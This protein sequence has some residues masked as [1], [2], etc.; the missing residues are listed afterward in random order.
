MASTCP[1]IDVAKCYTNLMLCV[2]YG[3]HFGIS[4]TLLHNISSDGSSV[5]V[6]DWILFAFLILPFIVSY[7]IS[8]IIII[9]DLYD[10]YN[11]DIGEMNPM[12]PF[13]LIYLIIIKQ[14][15][16]IQHLGNNNN[17]SNNNNNDNS[18]AFTSSNILLINYIFTMLTWM[19][20]S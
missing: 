11:D 8:M 9:Y 19:I 6:G 10:I 7:L 2:L 12:L 16:M 15:N 18:L 3:T 4:I 17:D 1:E 5:R 14:H 13:K 20:A